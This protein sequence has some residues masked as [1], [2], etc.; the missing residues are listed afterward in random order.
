MIDPMTTLET[1]VLNEG[2][3]FLFAQLTDV[4]K[5]FRARRAEKRSPDGIGEPDAVAGEVVP[6]TTVGASAL[7]G[8]LTTAHVDW[9]DVERL[10]PQLGELRR[11]LA[12]YADGIESISRDDVRGLALIGEARKI[13]E[14]VLGEHITFRGEP[15]PSSGTAVDVEIRAR[16]VD[17]YLAGV[18]TTPSGPTT[19]IRARLHIDTVGAGG[20]VIGVD[21]AAAKADRDGGDTSGTTGE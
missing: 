20:S 18:R 3:K 15:G 5:Q 21:A 7:E 8:S 17:G 16:Q 2:V 13:L 9:A 11:F 14:L 19:D 12:D 1:D 10:E 6:I 4:L